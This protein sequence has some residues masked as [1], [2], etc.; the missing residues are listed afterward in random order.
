[1]RK[2]SQPDKKLLVLSVSAMDYMLHIEG[3]DKND[4]PELLLSVESTNIP[5]LVRKFADNPK[6]RLETSLVQLQKQTLPDLLDHVDFLCSITEA[7]AHD[8][9]TFDFD[10]HEDRF[11]KQ[12]YSL[13]DDFEVKLINQMAKAISGYI[14]TW[15]LKARNL[16]QGWRKLHGTTMKAFLRKKGEHQTKKSNGPSWN[17]SLLS[18]PQKDLD[19]VWNS[20]DKKT[21]DFVEQRKKLVAGEIEFLMNGLRNSIKGVDSKAFKKNLENKGP[22]LQQAFD[23]IESAIRSGLKQQKGR[24]LED[25]NGDYFRGR[26]SS[27]YKDVVADQ[28]CKKH[29]FRAAL[30]MFENVMCGSESPYVVQIQGKFNEVWGTLKMEKKKQG[31]K[32]I[33]KVMNE[34]RTA[35][36]QLSVQQKPSES[37][38]K[39]CANLTLLVKEGRDQC[40]KPI[41][42][43]YLVSRSGR[44][45]KVEK[46]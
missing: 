41:R 6:Y 39:M 22:A 11:R 27:L 34:I 20:I 23:T 38:L 5:E 15:N 16:I 45:V 30:N 31:E 36:K 33:K 1:M 8:T 7:K 12:L 21:K 37:A 13:L 3:Y 26:M 18:G 25:S 42:T 2:Y 24:L 40:S 10:L 28:E 17:A 29:S 35:S 46:K 43:S 32:A 14:P 44:T 9:V 4:K 19:P